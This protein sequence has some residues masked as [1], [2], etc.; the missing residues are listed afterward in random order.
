MKFSSLTEFHITSL[1]LLTP[2]KCGKHLIVLAHLSRQKKTSHARPKDPRHVSLKE[3]S[4]AW[5]KKTKQSR[6][7]QANHAK[8]A[9]GRQTKIDQ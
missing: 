6:S 8:P 1:E 2:A 4:H 9:K 5:P 3:A 7:K